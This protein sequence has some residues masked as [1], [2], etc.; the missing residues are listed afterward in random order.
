ME[1]SDLTYM[2]VQFD[3]LTAVT[4]KS[5]VSQDMTPCSLVEAH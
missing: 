5:T 3:T 4:A 1:T 2:Y